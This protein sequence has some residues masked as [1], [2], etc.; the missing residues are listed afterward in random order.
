M[1]FRS[2][3]SYESTSILDQAQ[4]QDFANWRLSLAQIAPIDAPKLVDWVSESYEDFDPDEFKP[5][6]Q[7]P[8]PG[9]DQ[10]AQLGQQAP[11]SAMQA[12]AQMGAKKLGNLATAL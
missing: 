9:Q 2:K 11:G 7:P 5:K 12:N 10:Q 3:S 8:Q 6:Q 1:L 4:R